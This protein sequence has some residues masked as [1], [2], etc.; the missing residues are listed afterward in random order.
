VWMRGK[1]VERFYVCRSREYG[2]SRLCTVVLLMLVV[3]VA[4]ENVPL[5]GVFTLFA[6]SLRGGLYTLLAASSTG[7]AL[8]RG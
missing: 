2:I 1:S 6:P 5:S 4:D 7:L 3:V 8:W